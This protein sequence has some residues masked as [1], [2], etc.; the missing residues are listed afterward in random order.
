MFSSM[1]DDT[2]RPATRDEV[3]ETLGYALRFNRSGKSHRHASDMMAQIA[4]EVL[5][6]HL[7]RSG[8]VVMKKPPAPWPST[9]RYM[10]ARD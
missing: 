6:E 4:A 2:L 8:F 1:P 7:E 3:R 5:V 10:P 9:M